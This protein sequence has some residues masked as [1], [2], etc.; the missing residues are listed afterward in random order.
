[1]SGLILRGRCCRDWPLQPLSRIGK[2]GYCGQVPVVLGEWEA[3]QD[4]QR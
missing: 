3:T 1:M 2:C 4:E